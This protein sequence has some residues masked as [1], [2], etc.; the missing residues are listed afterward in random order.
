MSAILDLSFNSPYNDRNQKLSFLIDI[1]LVGMTPGDIMGLMLVLNDEAMSPNASNNMR[2]YDLNLNLITFVN[3]FAQVSYQPESDFDFI[4]NGDHYT[5]RAMLEHKN[6]ALFKSNTVVDIIPFTIPDRP[7]FSRLD[8]SNLNPLVDAGFDLKLLGIEDNSY[9]NGGSPLLSVKWIWSKVTGNGTGMIEFKTVTYDPNSNMYRIDVSDTMFADNIIDISDNYEVSVVVR[10]LAG[11]SLVSQGLV[12][13]AVNIP[14]RPLGLMALVDTTLSTPSTAVIKAVFHYP[15]DYARSNYRD[16]TYRVFWDL[17]SDLLGLNSSYTDFT[18]ASDYS[19]SY[20]FVNLPLSG[21]TVYNKTVYLKVQARNINGGSPLSNMTSIVPY[22]RSAAPTNIRVK[23]GPLDI[24]ENTSVNAANASND[25]SGNAI[26]YFSAPSPLVLGSTASF[27]RYEVIDNYD[28]VLGFNNNQNNNYVTLSGLTNFSPYNIRVRVQTSFDAQVYNGVPSAEYNMTPFKYPVNVDISYATEGDRHVEIEWTPS[29]SHSE[30]PVYYRIRS[31]LTNASD[32]TFT[33]ELSDLS[34]NFTDLL[35][36]NAYIFEITPFY[37][38]EQQYYTVDGIWVNDI[39][40]KYYGNPTTVTKIPIKN[41]TLGSIN[42]TA[43]LGPMKSDFSAANYANQ[44]QNDYTGNNKVVLSWVTPLQTDLSLSTYVSFVNYEI[45][46]NNNNIKRTITDRTQTIAILDNMDGVTNYVIER[47]KIRATVTNG[48]VQRTSDWSSLTANAAPFIYPIDISSVSAVENDAAVAVQW[49]A[50]D[51]HTGFSVHY[52]I[53]HKLST[54]SSYNNYIEVNNISYNFTGL[55]NSYSYDFEIT[56]F[57]NVNSN[58][59][60]GNSATISKTPIATPSLGSINFV[61]NLGPM[62]AD[63]TAANYANQIQ[64]DYTGNNKVVLTWNSPSDSDLGVTDDVTFVN[65]K[66][67]DSNDSLLAT[68]TDRDAVMEIL[69]AAD[70]VVNYAVERYKI[71]ATVSNGNVERT[72][73]PSDLTAE[74]A[75]FVYPIDISITSDVEDDA[76]VA[77]GWTASDSHDEFSVHYRIGHRLSGTSE[78]S[79]EEVDDISHNFDNLT[80][81]SSYDFEITP[82][83]TVNGENYY[84][85]SATISKTPIATPSLGDI[86]FVAHYGPMRLDLSPASYAEDASYSGNNMV[87]L[88]WNSPSDASLGL[89]SAVSFVN[90]K[91]YDSNNNPLATLT[92]RDAVTKLLT[93]GV[94][95]GNAKQYKITATVSNGN[96]ERTSSPS[97]LTVSIAPFTFP[98]APTGVGAVGGDNNITVSWTDVGSQYSYSPKYYVK[99]DGNT[100]EDVNDVSV[101]RTYTVYGRHSGDVATFIEAPTTVVG[102]T[103][104]YYSS[105]VDWTSVSYKTPDAVD[106]LQVLAGPLSAASPADAASTLSNVVSGFDGSNSVVL[107]WDQ[108]TDAELG[109]GNGIAFLK[110]VLTKPNGSTLD[111]TNRATVQ[112]VANAADGVADGAS[113][114]YSIVVYTDVSHVPINTVV[115]SS[116]SVSN[117]SF[118]F[119]PAL[120]GLGVVS[121]DTVANVSWNTFAHPITDIDKKFLVEWK[122]FS[123]ASW[124]DS[125][126][127]IDATSY[128]ITDL[129]NNETYNVRVTP[130]ISVTQSNDLGSNDYYGDAQTALAYPIGTPVAITN[131]NVLTGPLDASLNP[132]PFSGGVSLPGIHPLEGITGTNMVTFTWKNP[133]DISSWGNGSSVQFVRFE[134]EIANTS[135][136]FDICGN[137]L[138]VNRGAN[139][140]EVIAKYTR[141]IPNPNPSG[142]NPN[143]NVDTG[144]NILNGVSRKYRVRV[145]T[146]NNDA[147]SVFK[148]SEWSSQINARPF[149]RPNAVAPATLFATSQDQSIGLRWVDLGAQST[150]TNTKYDIYLGNVLNQTTDIDA[151]NAV[152]GGLTNGTRYNGSIRTVITATW[153]NANSQLS[154]YYANAVPFSAVP[155]TTPLAPALVDESQVELDRNIQFTLDNDANNNNYPLWTLNNYTLTVSDEDIHLMNSYTV[156]ANTSLYDV[157]SSPWGV[158]ANGHEYAFSIVGNYTY[159]DGSNAT[160]DRITAATTFKLSPYDKPIIDHINTIVGYNSGDVQIHVDPNGRPLQNVWLVGIPESLDSVSDNSWNF[161]YSSEMDS[162]IILPTE[163]Y[164]NKVL[165]FNDPFSKGDTDEFLKICY[166]FVSN[167]KGTTSYEEIHDVNFS[168]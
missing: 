49:A 11:E 74:A 112:Y 168:L 7:A 160:F 136:G 138:S 105:D 16:L 109:L 19:A 50:S 71:T 37:V 79:Y 120:T 56:P 102:T 122:L 44:I 99:G 34:F 113:K 22:S 20:I 166:M 65:F 167:E 77:L 27:V 47:Y 68:L 153:D 156:P 59:Y 104:R 38:V 1:S 83:Y 101:V 142:A 146:K 69:D 15:F 66:I 85:N 3:G 161:V 86:N 100:A 144:L 18:D 89:S 92:D 139:A 60:Y 114:N 5:A 78:F 87:V 61:A 21:S 159:N 29:D 116:S 30:F 17:S 2:Y 128:Q 35:N 82:F 10:N 123:A 13:N 12:L 84:G 149:Q 98:A 164:G 118:T 145:V 55:T 72:S 125:E 121:D 23:L 108:P 40:L 130:Y 158:M 14:D 52:R 137:F 129:S 33:A 151:N 163:K 93:N 9:W 147:T 107:T 148:Y 97:D 143:D 46:D 36:S 64:N 91:I 81:S 88:T 43:N 24:N 28:H 41:P 106:N 135:G 131:F 126:I 134:L 152:I 150:Y 96:V 157:A 154:E 26:V 4:R 70:G 111:I 39:T 53:G 80:N 57:Y 94:S 155:T 75:P 115:S 90:F 54:A 124:A 132:T 6:K 141:R 32:F 119:P 103:A 95:N 8:P 133:A 45:A 62:K 140:D 58:K 110:Y 73:E 162:T 67:Y 31:K 25:G 76:A 48:N 63:L 51:S 127:V 42:F 117:T 165:Q